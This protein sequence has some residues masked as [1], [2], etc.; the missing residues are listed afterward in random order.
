MEN[1]PENQLALGA[2]QVESIT[3]EVG[4]EVMLNLTGTI[5]EKTDA[6]AVI[7]DISINECEAV[8]QEEPEE[9][10][11]P[12]ASEDMEEEAPPAKGKMPKA[13]AIIMTGKPKGK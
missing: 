6:G 12:E 8:E 13:I 10:E 5:T 2:D 3:Q 1:A 9:T 4:E 7:A 11:A